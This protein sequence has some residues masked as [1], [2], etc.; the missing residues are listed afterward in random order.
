MNTMLS[1]LPREIVAMVGERIRRRKESLR[2]VK[3]YKNSGIQGWFKVETIA[4]LRDYVKEVRDK[5][6]DLVLEIHEN[7]MG[8]ELVAASDS[9]PFNIK[10]RTTQFKTLCLFLG[11]G[12]DKE[13]IEEL[14]SDR[15]VEVVTHETFRDDGNRWIIGLV[16]PSEEYLFHHQE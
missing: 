15:D 10:L 7:K 14:L 4:A 3:G 9:N 1:H 2:H 13:R 16:K 6:P 12:S 11:D 8:I 5:G